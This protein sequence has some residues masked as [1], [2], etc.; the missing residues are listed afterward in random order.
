MTVSAGECLR[1]QAAS[2]LLMPVKMEIFNQKACRDTWC[3]TPLHWMLIPAQPAIAPIAPEAQEEEIDDAVYD[4][5]EGDEEG[6]EAEIV[7][8]DKVAEDGWIFD[9]FA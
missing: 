5:F 9:L 1:K 2:S 8:D 4:E 7:V 6:H 3:H